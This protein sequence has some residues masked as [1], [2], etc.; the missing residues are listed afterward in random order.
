MAPLPARYADARHT[1]LYSAATI[2]QGPASAWDDV[3]GE[4]DWLPGG[5][6][7]LAHEAIDRHAA[8][9]TADATALIWEGGLGER[10]EYTF[11][12]M[13]TLSNLF[14]SVLRNLG[15]V[16]GD[17]VFI[18]LDSTPE[19]FVAFLGSLKVGAVACALPPELEP[20]D[21]RVRLAGAGAKIVV[22]DPR[23]RRRLSAI[24]YHLFD[25][26]H[27]VVVN[28][29]GRDPFPID[30]ADLSY[31]EEMLKASGDSVVEATGQ[32]DP[33]LI[34]Y[35][36]C[37]GAEPLGS[38]HRQVSAAQHLV[39]ARWAL[40]L[41]TGDI[42]WCAA[43]PGSPAWP[44]VGLLAPWMAGATI[45]SVEALVDADSWAGLVSRHGV[46]VAYVDADTARN[47]AGTAPPSDGSPALC[48][49]LIGAA[50]DSYAVSWPEDAF[51]VP[52]RQC[53][54]QAETGTVVVADAGEAPRCGP[55]GMPAPGI[56]VSIRDDEMRRLPD[57]ETGRL[58]LRPGG[59]SMFSTY[60]GDTEAYNSRFNRGWYV[61]GELARMDDEGYV[62]LEGPE[63]NME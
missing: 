59:P 30:P 50:N 17:R 62:W 18:L 39:T 21:A 33:A 45:L 36:Q 11:A 49:L 6:L 24:V 13:K 22:T 19:L 55:A 1:T 25:L 60:W 32:Y 7:N 51:G 54:S 47:I 38:L 28:K 15:V 57:G 63:S 23:V 14:A 37:E 2:V 26:Q 42:Y 41:D 20:D 44:S 8:T 27:I 53:W 16:K 29:N 56:E 31:E 12:E 58:T 46:S 52:F 10:E 5:R 9:E 40:R 43:A 61:T 3:C 4:L 34:D 35:S 48:R